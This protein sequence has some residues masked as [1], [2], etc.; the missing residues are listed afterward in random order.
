VRG[1]VVG[2][3]A[4]L[5]AVQIVRNAAVGAFSE[6]RPALAAKFWAGHPAVE[7]SSALE[8]IGQASHDRRPIDPRAFALIDDAAIKA[9]LAPEPFLVAGVRAETAGEEQDASLAFHAAQ[10]RD[11]RSLPAAFFL[12]QY[13]LRQGRA[14]DGLEQTTLVARLAPGGLGAVAP[15][16]ATF[17]QNRA[18]WP[19]IRTLF[20]SQQGLEEQV[21]ASLA[22]NGRNADAI[23]ALADANHRNPDSLWLHK[24]LQSLVAEG[25]YGRAKAIWSSF[26]GGGTSQLIFDSSFSAP[27]PPPPFNWSLTT[28]TVGL[29]ERQPGRRLHAIFY[30]NDDGVLVS[31][32]LTL[33][34]GTYRLQMQLVGA[35]EHPEELSW[36]ITCDKAHEPIASIDVSKA[37]AR[38]LTFQVPAH[39]PAQWLQLSARSGDI[40]QQAEVTIT[41]LSLTRV[42]TNG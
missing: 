32:L 19:Q 13:Y 23:L 22:R 24:L 42:G 11:P 34:P 28:S 9:P 29:A 26:G 1:L 8:M 31:E 5:L 3:I 35:P 30:G 40:S 7:I 15:F 18:N 2:V 38:G 36:L 21:L 16:V 14:L 33:P 17:A 10:W 41:G 37:A 6:L 27:A 4:L 25:D 12:A 20:R 39:C